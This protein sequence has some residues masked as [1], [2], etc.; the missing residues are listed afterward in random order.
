MAD[1]QRLMR[2]KSSLGAD[3]FLLRDMHLTEALGQPFTIELKIDSDDL[4]ISHKDI[5]GDHLS[6]EFDLA[7]GELRYF[8]GIVT[9]FSYVGLTDNRASYQVVL[10]PWLWVLSHHMQC[11]IFQGKTVPDI[12][13]DIFHA[14]KFDDFEDKLQRGDYLKLDYCVQYR[15]SDF[16]FVSRLMEQEG[17]YYYF[18]HESGVHKLVL[19]DGATGHAKYA[20]K[21]GDIKIARNENDTEVGTVWDWALGHELQSGQ[22]THTDYDLEKPNADLKK[23]KSMAQGHKEDSFEIYDY[24]GKYT[25]ASDG[26]TYAGLRIEEQVAQFERAS[27][28]SRTQWIATGCLITMKDSQRKGHNREYLIVECKSSVTSEGTGAGQFSFTTEFHAL[29]TA[30]T[31]RAPRRTHKPFIRGPQTAFVV[32][33]SG[34]EIWTDKYGRVKVQFHWDRDGQNDEKSSCWVRCAQTWAGKSWGGMFIPRV[35]QEVII[36]FLEGDP[37][38]PII[39]GAVY[40]ASSMPPYGLPDEAT[41]S[42]IKSNSSKGGNGFNEIR[43]EDKAGSEEFYVHA[44]KDQNIEVEKGDRS[45][46]VKLG[47]EKHEVSK[48]KLT[49]KIFGDTSLTVDTGN[50]DVKISTGSASLKATQGITIESN[51]SITL[52]VANNSVTI[53]MTGITIK[54]TMVSVSGDVSTQIKGLMTDVEASAMLQL[55]G[56]I[57]MLG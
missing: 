4:D 56:G 10:R 5:L 47:D 40:N 57:T 48:G 30:Q 35:G 55:K 23:S 46:T 24:P 53:D 38:R 42:T 16:A 1:K 28:K 22:Y 25:E 45:L 52:K 44:Q 9:S 49:T 3:K 12:I 2:V 29:G 39:T 51:M 13:K 54:G 11:K 26:T 31:F 50:Y 36:H 15:E 19:C 32:G 21:Y 41:K 17:I 43:F 8:D 33:K 14:A 18:K 20:G 37:D 27:G 34:E 7:N 6:L